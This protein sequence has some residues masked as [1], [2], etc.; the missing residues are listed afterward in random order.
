[1]AA[2]L[3]HY[4]TETGDLPFVWGERDCTLWVA[5]WWVARYGEDPAQEFRDRYTTR[6]EAEDFV[7]GDLV[8]LIGRYVPQ[9]DV[10]ERGDIGVVEIMGREV[11]AICTGSHWA[12]KTE[13][14]LLVTRA[15][16]KAVWG[17]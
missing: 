10:A 12:V 1:M 4:L 7:D 8:G 17:K 2:G 3:E 16:P 15:E 9:K 11:A 14:G 6:E 13:G 5:D